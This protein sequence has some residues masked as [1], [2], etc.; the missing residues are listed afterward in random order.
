MK[1]LLEEFDEL[2]LKG[3][4]AFKQ[5]RTLMRAKNIAY[6]ILNCMGKGTITGFL[7][8]SGKQF[9]DWSS[10][11]RLFQ[12]DKMD[13]NELFSAVRKELIN[14]KVGEKSPIYAHMDDTLLRKTGRKV[15]GTAW[16]RDPLGPPFHTNFIWGQRFIQ[17]S[18]SLPND[19]GP[20]ISRA[21]PIDLHHCPTVSKP[22][23]SDS[24]SVWN[25]YKEKQKKLKLSQKG[26]DRIHVL[27]SKLDSDGAKENQLI[28]SVDGSYTNE[29]VLKNLPHRVT[30]I[31][32]VRKDTSFFELPDI[33]KNGI[34]RNR[35]YGDAIPSPEQ[36][37]LSDDYKWQ[38]V[39]A[40]AA[41]KE[42]TF[43]VKVV[44]NIRWKKAGKQNLQ[45]I[46]IR[47]LAY[48]L[49]KKSRLL[50]RQPAYLICTDP[51]LN[52]QELLQAYLW[53]W[54]IE[55]NF[56]EEKSILGCGQAQVRTETPV[57]KIPA[58]I[59]AVYAFIQLAAYKIYTVKNGSQLPRTKWYKKHKS[60]RITTGDILNTF[61]T[62]L[63]A[64]YMDVNFDHFVKL[65]TSMRNGQN[66]SNPTLAAA[67]YSRK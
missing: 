22:K 4:A 16:R 21:I 24:Q 59:V 26:I 43:N 15:S 63:W 60:T 30:L 11:Y 10:D 35:V 45:V 36:I 42:H 1:F 2:F 37:R 8:S 65:Q 18:I 12:G 62:Q 51:N 47:P 54:E 40:F 49:T 41:R 25:N 13:V 66:L 67:F 57:E 28:V 52:I 7:T 33:T 23:K 55:V 32:R 44:K 61:K 29:T 50:Y 46:V 48:R 34:G 38:E 64:K 31:G 53:R 3:R 58:F 27:R 9:Q 14:E 19:N 5:T 6:G 39:N 56:R 20:S 17:L